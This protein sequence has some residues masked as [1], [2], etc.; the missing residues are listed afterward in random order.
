M[1]F[2]N[3]NIACFSAL[4]V[5]NVQYRLTS[6]HVHFQLLALT[7]RRI[8]GFCWPTDQRLRAVT[9]VKNFELETTIANEMNT[10]KQNVIHLIGSRSNHTFKKKD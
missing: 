6:Q 4:Q 2:F 1:S 7:G 10:S 3:I 8:C 5:L 9:V